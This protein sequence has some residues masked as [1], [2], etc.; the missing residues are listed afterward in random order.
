[1][2]P[3]VPDEVCDKLTSRGRV[4]RSG[5]LQ[6]FICQDG[7]VCTLTHYFLISVHHPWWLFEGFV[8]CSILSIYFSAVWSTVTAAVAVF[9]AVLSVV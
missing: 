7:I 1:M 3:V 6:Q 5:G 8:V 9:F 2:A 4:S